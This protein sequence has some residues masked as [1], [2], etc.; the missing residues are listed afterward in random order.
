MRALRGIVLAC[1]VCVAMTTRPPGWLPAI[2]LNPA[3]SLVAGQQPP[4]PWEERLLTTL[5]PGVDIKRNG[6]PY[7]LLVSNDGAHVAYVARYREGDLMQEAVV[8]D[9][10]RGPPSSFIVQVSLSPDGEK[11]AYLAS[12]RDNVTAAYLVVGNRRDQVQIKK[13]STDSNWVPVFSADGR[14]L[15]YKVETVSGKRAIKLAD[16]SGVP[17]GIH[18]EASYEPLA[19]AA[20]PEFNDVD[21]P[22]FSA[23]GQHVTYAAL[24]AGAWYIVIDGQ[25]GPRFTDAAAPVFS[26]DG[27]RVGY[28]ATDDNRKYFAVNGEARGPLFNWVGPPSFAPDGRQ[29]AYG[30]K[31]GNRT[32]LVVGDERRPAKEVAEEV[33]FS[34][35]GSRTTYWTKRISGSKTSVVI[36]GEAGPK[37]DQAGIPV[38]DATARVGAYWARDG[39]RF[40]MMAGGTRSDTFDGVSSTR[41]FSPDGTMLGFAVLQ[42]R[43]VRW[44]VMRLSADRAPHGRDTI[45]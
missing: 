30:A 27:R 1:L 12:P 41:V 29:L 8:H 26:P 17:A 22:R 5:P 21:Q 9:G 24:D 11:V 40:L 15:A 16:L 7:S 4:G 34:R 23:D 25:P 6:L 32:W 2:P 42:G 38:F 20:G 13:G 18:T 44:K 28:R 31:E 43:E 10:R 3:V 19:A 39:S 45:Q 14:K 37:F 35:D 36:D 33:V